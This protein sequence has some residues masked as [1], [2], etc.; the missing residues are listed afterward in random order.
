MSAG[1]RRAIDIRF[2]RSAADP[3]DGNRC[4]A[5]A[6]TEQ[7]RLSESIAAVRSVCRR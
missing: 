3:P 6:R 7:E 4:T 2:H 1:G 5:H